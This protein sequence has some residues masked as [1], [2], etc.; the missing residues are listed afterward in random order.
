MPTPLELTS[1]FSTAHQFVQGPTG[2]HE[3]SPPAPTASRSQQIPNI[4]I[5][6]ERQ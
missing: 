1:S 2:V 4:T 3:G 5:G 6:N